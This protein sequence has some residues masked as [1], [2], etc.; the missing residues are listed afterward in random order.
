M[1]KDIQEKSN[2]EKFKEVT[3]LINAYKLENTLEKKEVKSSKM[4]I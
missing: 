2:I 4:K 3:T 1:S